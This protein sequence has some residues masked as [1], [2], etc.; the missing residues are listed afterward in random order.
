MANAFLQVDGVTG[1]SQ[2][3]QHKG[4]IDVESLNFGVA[5]PGGMSHGSGGGVGRAAFEDLVVTA[6]PDSGTMALFGYAASGKH[7]NKV[8]L[9][10]H[11]AGGKNI[12]YLR[13]T[14]EDVIVT[15]VQYQNF[16]NNILTVVYQFQAARVHQSYWKQLDSGGK[17]AECMT[18]WDIKANK[19]V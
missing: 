2:D 14:L 16:A 1:E 18:G 5:Q 10:L 3:A 13:I 4:W 9:S 7:V 8:I 15:R 17:G 11:K 19:S 6:R 12:E